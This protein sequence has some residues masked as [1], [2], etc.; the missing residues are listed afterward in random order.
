MRYGKWHVFRR[1]S[2]ITRRTIGCGL[3]PFEA[4]GLQS[5]NRESYNDMSAASG[6]FSHEQ[7]VACK[8]GSFW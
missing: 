1:R 6:S 2:L 7:R 3:G 8:D 4:G 5:Q